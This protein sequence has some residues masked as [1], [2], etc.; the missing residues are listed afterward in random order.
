MAAG[1]P[2]FAELVATLVRALAVCDLDVGAHY[3]ALAPR[4]E[5]A[6]RIWTALRTEHE[7]CVKRVLAITG[8]PRLLDPSPAAR[9]RHARRRPWLD[10]LS[11]LQVELLRRHRAGDEQ[12]TEPLL[13]TIAGVA[14]GL[15]TTG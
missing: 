8:H 11:F 2:F 3:L 14:A 13:A 10:A 1:W 5:S 7:R 9:A 6:R 4:R 12:A 15:R